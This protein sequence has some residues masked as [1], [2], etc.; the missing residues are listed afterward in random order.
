M[1][2]MF[3]LASTS[4][5]ARAAMPAAV[6]GFSNSASTRSAKA[7]GWSASAQTWPSARANPSAPNVVETTGM[8]AANA[9]SS[10]TRTPE[11]LRMGQTNTAYRASGSRTSSTYPSISRDAE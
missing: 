2:A 6:S 5:R 7:A 10:F 4:A 1:A 9:S 11:P 8:P 3:Q